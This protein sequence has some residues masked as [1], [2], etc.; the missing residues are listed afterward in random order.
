MLGNGDGTFQTPVDY[1]LGDNVQPGNPTVA[2]GDF[3][4]DGIA[5][6]ALTND[7][8]N[9]LSVLLGNGDGTL[10]AA[11]DYARGRC[12]HAVTVGDFNG[13]GAPD[14]AFVTPP[15]DLSATATGDLSILLNTGVKA[16]GFAVSATPGSATLSSG[17]AAD[18]NVTSTGMNGFEGS[19]SL[20][21]SV[22]PTPA[23]APTC[24]LNPQSV[25]LALNGS[26]TAKLTITTTAP[27]ASLYPVSQHD[28][29]LWSALCFPVFGF[30]LV[31]TGSCRP[32][33]RKILSSF[34]LGLALASL[35]LELACGGG[36]PCST[37]TT[38]QSGTPAGQYH[39]TV[40]ANYASIAHSSAV[41]VT[42][43]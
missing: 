22:S 32:S 5:D 11:T 39:V 26:A 37:C 27:T 3:N 7:F 21:C 18:F 4:G 10:Q 33:K 14:L 29:R 15:S 24:A 41:T 38:T 6:L 19:V 13:D 2:I 34:L 36:S 17:S 30:A 1:S 31:G 20:S 23:L 12:N 25:D 43:Q 16:K 28:W 35:L 9:V 42:V 40:T 8:D